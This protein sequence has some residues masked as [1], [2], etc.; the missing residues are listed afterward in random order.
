VARQDWN[1]ELLLLNT[2]VEKLDRICTLYEGQGDP[3]E[4]HEAIQEAQ[5]LIKGIDRSPEEGS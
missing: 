5:T 1:P 4:M 2:L 3:Q